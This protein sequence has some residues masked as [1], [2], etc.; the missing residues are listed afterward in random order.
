MSTCK[1]TDDT[2]RDIRAMARA[3]VKAGYL[4]HAE[5]VDKIDEVIHEHTPLDKSEI[6]DIVSGYGQ[7][8]KPT[9]NELQQKLNA[10]KKT[11]REEAKQRPDQARAIASKAEAS[12]NATRQKALQKQLDEYQRKI[13]TDDFSKPVRTPVMY[14]EKTMQLQAKVNKAKI[15]A[16]K[17]LR[18]IERANRGPFEKL[19]DR[20]LVVRRA[21]MLSGSPILAKLSAAAS[22]RVG[23]TP[24]EGLI[25]QG[26][27]H[28][29]YL[30]SRVYAHTAYEGGSLRDYGAGELEAIRHT[31]SSDVFREMWSKLKGY[32]SLKAAFGKN[33]E[34]DNIPNV[35]ELPGR[36]HGVLKTP[37]EMNEYHRALTKYGLAERRQAVA[38]GMTP[39]QVEQHLSDPKTLASVQLK[40]FLKSQEAV[41]M[42]DNRA[43]N[44]IN[45]TINMMK[46]AGVAEGKPNYLGKTVAG[47]VEFELP[48]KKVA[49]NIVSETS[50]YL[51]GGIKA[52]MH[53]MATKG[54]AL[55]ADEADTVAR[56]LQKQTVGVALATVGWLF[57]DGFGGFYQEGKKKKPGDVG[58]GDAQ[59]GGQRVSKQVMHT[60]AASVLQVS[61]DARRA[62]DA[63][64]GGV[65]G[66]GSAAFTSTKDL[67]GELPFIDAPKRLFN[68]LKDSQ[69]AGVF[70]GQNVADSVIPRDLQNYAKSGDPEQAMKRKPQGF[71]DAIKE[72]I[73]GLR[74]QVPLQSYKTLSLDQR[75][76]AWD[77]M[78]PSQRASSDFIKHVMASARHN[79]KHLT[80][81]QQDHL[82]RIVQQAG[83]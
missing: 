43:N 67:L 9:R 15:D 66:V 68:A 35:L 32:S 42:Q 40:A 5:I 37:A 16:M 11:M 53:I 14:D 44:L 69:S 60:P 4:D 63:S 41:L 26:L 45:N 57:A 10:V 54:K 81:A 82:A 23:L 1:P 2:K 27:K 29:P 50:S 8:S 20:F 75:M 47:A 33:M 6:A 65:S 48:F 77:E 58:Y 52:A 18:K 70:L 21:V 19:W 24:I 28:V 38:A 62:Y 12:K 55:T 61:A 72:A 46:H 71:T 78:S 79:E 59:I 49:T 25:G 39:D 17:A 74:E 36:I 7:E 56:F 13:D 80:Q 3:L 30:G 31:L 34:L 73:P 76:N 64:G 83:Q 22:L 51:A